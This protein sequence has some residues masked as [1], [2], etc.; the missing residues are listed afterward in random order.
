VKV[1]I[2]KHSGFTLIE[3][4]VVI[5]I[6]A[7]LASMLL[8]ALASS[9][10][11]AKMINEISSAKQLLFAYQTY[12][13]DHE[14]RLMPGYRYGYPAVDRSGEAITHPI[15]ARYPWRLAP[16]LGDSFPV[17]YVNRNRGLLERFREH[18][19]ASYT[20]A[21]SVFPSLGINSIYVGGDDLTLPPTTKAFKKFGRFCALKDTD[22]NA[23]S[24]LNVFVSARGGFEGD[25]VDGNYRVEAPYLTSRS[26]TP[27]YDEN[28]APEQFGFVHPRYERKAVAGI[29]DGHAEAL[30]INELQDMRRWSMIADRRDWVLSPLQ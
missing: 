2:K 28:A 4:L 25:I 12:A 18:D 3:L 8:P 10:T 24:R 16:Y 29:F 1:D 19:D 11:R 23:P 7:I 17:M 26:W 15:N 5:A 14:G 13:N 27:T 6:I 9:K 30:S 22:P 20:Y 21:S